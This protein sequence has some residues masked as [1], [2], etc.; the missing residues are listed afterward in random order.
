MN[1]I[2]HRSISLLLAA[3]TI[4]V[5]LTSCEKDFGDINKSWDNKVY[6]ATIPALFNGITA[7]MADAPVIL[8]S[9]W[10]YQN[11]QLAA[12]YAAGGFRLDNF[13]ANGWNN[14]YRA[15]ANYRK[16]EEMIDTDANAANM[17][18]VKAMAKVL[19]A[20]KT[21]KLTLMYGDMPYTDAGKG[22]VSSDFFRPKYDSQESVI[23]GAL[24][25]LKWAIDNLSMNSSQVSLGSAEVI[26]ANDISKWI[27]LANSLR[28]RY[29]MVLLEKAPTDANTVLTEALAKPLLEPGEYFG[30]YPASLPN[31]FNNRLIGGN[32]GYVS[33]GST[34]W[35]SMSSSNE[36]DGSGIF[37]LRC[38]IFFEPNAFGEWVPFPQAPSNDTPTEVGNEGVNAPTA[39]AGLPPIILR[40]LHGAIRP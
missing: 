36:K 23:K 33:M 3:L 10:I 5:F 27:K 17:T 4:S 29:A 7:S 11:T 35:S 39:K 26:F 12:M 40:V 24:A 6:E 31:F 20:Y 13:T 19:M 8:Y 14:Y 34:M 28:L 18:N 32:A 22:F 38:R 9:C 16:L 25:E 37:D 21:L 1:I 2:K 30:L 15:L